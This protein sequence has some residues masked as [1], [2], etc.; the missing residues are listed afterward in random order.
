[1][2]AALGIDFGTESVRAVL[3]DCADGTEIGESV[4]AYEHGVIDERLPSP[5]EDVVLE[6]DWA[7]Q[8]PDDYVARSRSGGAAPACRDAAASRGRRRHRHRLHVLHDAPD[9]RRRDTS[10]PAR[11]A[12]A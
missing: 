8:D 6:P 5:D 3:V 1:M 11:G 2:K 12:A 7:L 10:L 9:S 4:E